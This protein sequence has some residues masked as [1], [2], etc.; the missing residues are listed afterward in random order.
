M[1]LKEIVRVAA[2]GDLHYGR[3][4]TPGSSAAAFESDQRERRCPRDLRRPD[5][6]RSREEARALAA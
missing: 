1:P 4:A 3:N 6:L 5:R 2:I